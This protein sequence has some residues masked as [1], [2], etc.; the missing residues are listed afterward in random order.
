MLTFEQIEDVVCN[1]LGIEK[2][3]IFTKSRKRERVYARQMCMLMMSK[4]TKATLKSI[5][6]HF[7][8]K[9]HTTVIHSKSRINDLCDA[10]QE[11]RDNV[12]DIIH[13]LEE[14]KNTPVLVSA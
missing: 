2:E 8:G 1:Y 14:L 12:N 6:Q 5:G 13:L 10:H 9:D 7:G 11:D 3:L 4:Y